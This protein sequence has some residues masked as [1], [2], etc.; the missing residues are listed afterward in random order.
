MLAARAGAWAIAILLSVA[1]INRDALKYLEWTPDVY[2]RFWPTRTSLAL[3]VAFAGVALLAAPLQFSKSVRKRVPRLHRQLGWIYVVCVLISI[4]AAFRLSFESCPGCRPPFILWSTI[5]IV[6]TTLAI[7]NAKRRKFS[8]HRDFM[9]RSY[10]LM[11][12]FVFVRLDHHLIG[13]PL[14]VPLPVDVPGGR[15]PMLLWVAWVVPLFLTELWL[16]WLPASFRS[17]R[18]RRR[19]FPQ[20]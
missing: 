16:V 7:W 14:E 4:P 5:T 11:L 3:H 17:N 12:G 8:V 6:V 2:S 20:P 15:A 19:S 18:P 13:T 10:V 1:F 9:F